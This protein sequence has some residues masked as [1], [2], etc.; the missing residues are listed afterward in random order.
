MEI[1]VFRT[2]K[3]DMMKIFE[4]FI[5]IIRKKNLDIIIDRKRDLIFLKDNR[6]SF[7]C[8]NYNKVVG[9]RPNYYNTDNPNASKF[10]SYSAEKVNGSEFYNFEE[11]LNKLI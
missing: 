11:L 4:E 1:V 2:F 10:I 6:I 8:G 3:S 5:N 7:W 9:I